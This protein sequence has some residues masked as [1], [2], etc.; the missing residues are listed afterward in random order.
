MRMWAEAEAAVSEETNPIDAG[1][2]L[3][4]KYLEIQN[5]TIKG[6]ERRHCE[7]PLGR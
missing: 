1:D 4:A 2:E 6:H 5:E 7:Q 3:E